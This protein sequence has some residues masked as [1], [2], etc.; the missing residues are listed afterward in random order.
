MRRLKTTYRLRDFSDPMGGMMMRTERRYQ[1]G[2]VNRASSGLK[3]RDRRGIFL[4]MALVVIAVCTMAAYSFTDLMLAYDESTML[5]GRKTQADM[6]VESGTEF[7]RLMLS[8]TPNARDDQGGVND[9]PA[10]F[11]AINVVPDL[12]PQR[13]GNFTIIAPAIDALGQ[14]AGV[15]Y[16]LQNESARLN[17]NTLTVIE[18][19]YSIGDEALQAAADLGLADTDQA[20]ISDSIARDLLM[21]LPNMTEDVADAILDWLDEDDEQRDFGAEYDYYNSLPTPYNPRNGAIDSVEELLL[22]RVVT[23]E[24]LFGA[25]TNRNGIIDPVEQFAVTGEQSTASLG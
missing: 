10:M 18:E 5:A 11:Q 23:P 12:D 22:V 2:R 20:M 25:D 19:N 6:L 14:F 3:S 9:N 17:V 1:Q 24:L 4:V 13:R 15:R 21:G 16:G 8:Q 7:A